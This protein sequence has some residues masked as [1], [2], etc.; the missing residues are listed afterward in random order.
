MSIFGWDLPPG[1]SARD[2]PGNQ[3]SDAEAFYDA[4]YEQFPATMAD[5]DKERI[6]DWVWERINTAYADGYAQGQADEK[7]GHEHAET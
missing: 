1:V 4:L 5:A 3:Q 2:L 6:A 7:E